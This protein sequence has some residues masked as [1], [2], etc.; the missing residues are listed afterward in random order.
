MDALN[1]V[2]LGMSVLVMAGVEFS[3]RAGLPSR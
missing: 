3:K 2:A 1:T